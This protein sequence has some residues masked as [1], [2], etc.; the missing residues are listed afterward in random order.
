MTRHLIIFPEAEP[1]QITHYEDPKVEVI[2]PETLQVSIA[3][4]I[5]PPSIEMMETIMQNIT[6][7]AYSQ[8]IIHE[9]IQQEV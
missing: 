9:P 3:T 8:P 6:I 2:D 1:L 4:I 7:S 5:Q